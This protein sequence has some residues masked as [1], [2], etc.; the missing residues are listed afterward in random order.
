MR[1]AHE[2]A[3]WTTSVCSGSLILAAAGVLDGKRATSH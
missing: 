3:T 2:T 1:R